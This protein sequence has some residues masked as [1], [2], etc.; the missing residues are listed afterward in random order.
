MLNLVLMKLKYNHLSLIMNKKDKPLDLI[1]I[2]ESKQ[3][4]QCSTC[5]HSKLDR[6]VK[7]KKNCIS[8]DIIDVSYILYCNNI[9][10]YVPLTKHIYAKCLLKGQY[11][12]KFQ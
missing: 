6:V 5:A 10:V 12:N 7:V 2:I 8:T 1:K 11:K 9:D 3:N 4:I